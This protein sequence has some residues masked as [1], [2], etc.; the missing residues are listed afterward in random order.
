MFPSRLAHLQ[1]RLPLPQRV[2]DAHRHQPTRTRVLFGRDVAISNRNAPNSPSATTSWRL[3]SIVGSATTR[4]SVRSS[5]KAGEADGR[6]DVDALGETQRALAGAA[7]EQFARFAQ[8]GGFLGRQQRAAGLRVMCVTDV[9]P[10]TA[11]AASASRPP[12][13]PETT[14]AWLPPARA[15]RRLRSTLGSANA[16][17]LTISR[18]MPRAQHGRRMAAQRSMAGELHDRVRLQRQQV[19][20]AH[21][22]RT[23]TPGRGLL[24]CATSAPTTSMPSAG[25]SRCQERRGRSC[26]ARSVRLAYPPAYP[27]PTPLSVNVRTYAQPSS[28][29]CQN[30]LR[31]QVVSIYPPRTCSDCSRFHPLLALDFRGPRRRPCSPPRGQPSP[32]CAP[33]AP[34][35]CPMCTC[36]CRTPIPTAR[37]RCSWRCT[38]WAATATTSAA[39]SPTG[40]RP[41]L[42]HRRA[43]HPLRRLDQSRGH[44]PRRPALIAWL[45]D[46]LQTLGQRTVCPIESRVLLFGHSRGAQLALR[47]TEIHPEQVA[48]VAAVSAAP[49]RCRCRRM[50]AAGRRSTS[51]SGSPTWRRRMAARR[52]TRRLQRGS[53]LDWRGRRRQ[54]HRGRTRARGVRISARTRGARQNFTS[55][56]PKQGADVSL[57][58]FPRR[59]TR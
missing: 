49:I 8:R 41:R 35:R 59:I 18:S 53:D 52:S 50:P 40:R 9:R 57:T 44:R 33:V 12:M 25:C 46:Y 56:L 37:C 15:A 6:G 11:A 38:A 55:A 32:R 17:T 24:G 23:C 10:P 39:P 13:A 5:P 31:H 2:Q 34:A 4:T 21:A 19:L 29:F 43:N 27:P 30:V 14:M 16:P 47:F 54:Q 58:I 26:R 45:A 51:R 28:P 36:A 7:A 1:V 48:G 20:D 42:G 22:P 3:R